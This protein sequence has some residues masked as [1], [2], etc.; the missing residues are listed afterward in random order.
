MGDVE[1]HVQHG[2]KRLPQTRK[3]VIHKI[4]IGDFE[5]YL[6]IGLYEDGQPG[7]VFIEA[8]KEGSTISG[9]LDTIGIQT[10]LLLQYGVPLEDIARKFIGTRFEPLG[11]TQ[12]DDI[13]F[14]QSIVDYVFR[15]LVK[16][17]LSGPVETVSGGFCPEDGC[18]APLVFSEGCEVCHACG[19]SKC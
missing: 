15:F 12:N 14:A 2:R 6:I 9:L 13:P 1:E 17:F 10:S 16:T 5:G 4:D 3:G 18:H 8:S 11:R 19:Y 7:E